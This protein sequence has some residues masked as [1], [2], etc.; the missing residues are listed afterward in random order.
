M[1][2]P[3]FILEMGGHLIGLAHSGDILPSPF[4]AAAAVAIFCERDRQCIAATCITKL[5]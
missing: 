4:F 5:E 3:V 2:A 1:T